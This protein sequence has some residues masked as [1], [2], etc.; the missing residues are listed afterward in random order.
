MMRAACCVPSALRQRGLLRV[1][2]PGTQLHTAM[3]PDTSHSHTCVA[4]NTAAQMQCSLEG[5][6]P[7]L[8]PH[9]SHF[10]LSPHKPPNSVICFPQRPPADV[11]V[12]VYSGTSDA[13]F[14]TGGTRAWVGTLGL[15]QG[16]P[17]YAW[18]DPTLLNE[19]RGGRA[20]DSWDAGSISTLARPHA[21]E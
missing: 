16:E 3:S 9:H 6:C 21:A 14:T 1:C 17:F 15:A 20:G 12:L 8:Q 19:V 13:V 2:R 7:R 18:R 11:R 10:P 4:Y 5:S